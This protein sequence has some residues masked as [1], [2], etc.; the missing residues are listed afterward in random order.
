VEVYVDDSIVS[1]ALVPAATGVTDCEGRV[2]IKPFKNDAANFST[3]QISNGAT[4]KNLSGIS[5]TIFL[6]GDTQ[7]ATPGLDWDYSPKAGTVPVFFITDNASFGN[8]ATATHPVIVVPV[9]QQ[10][11]VNIAALGDFFMGAPAVPLINLAAAPSGL[12]VLANNSFG[13]PN[14]FA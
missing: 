4:L 14:D 10:L 11:E 6:A 12:F 2:V 9:N 3:L 1:P 8:T 5:G 7:G 13:I